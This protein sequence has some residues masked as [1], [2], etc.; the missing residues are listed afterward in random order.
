MLRI[1]ISDFLDGYS[2]TTTQQLGTTIGY[3]NLTPK[4]DAGRF[5]LALYAIA[6][7]NVMGGFL[8]FGREFL[9]S[10]CTETD[11]EVP[12]AN[13]APRRRTSR[14]AISSKDVGKISKE[15]SS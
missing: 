6:N 5:L 3:G 11:L 14:S 13:A 1:S 2:A 10:Y 8:G 4:T 9:E 7:C 12:T 15:K